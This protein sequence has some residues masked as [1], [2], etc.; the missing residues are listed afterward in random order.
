[1]LKQLTQQQAEQPSHHPSNTIRILYD[2]RQLRNTSM[3]A[4]H[5]PTLCKNSGKTT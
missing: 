2:E 4:A 5:L 1:M 3:A